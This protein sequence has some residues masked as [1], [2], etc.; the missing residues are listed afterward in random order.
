MAG[1]RSR[2]VLIVDDDARVRHALQALLDSFDGLCPWGEAVA[3]PEALAADEELEP[4]VVL[5]DLL[6][7]SAAEGLETLGALVARG[8]TVVAMSIRAGLATA[9]VEAGAAAFVEKGVSADH[10]V[11]TLRRASP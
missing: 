10:L 11:D 7:P 6:L 9:A 1:S 2:R 4:D 8:R 5:L 3:G